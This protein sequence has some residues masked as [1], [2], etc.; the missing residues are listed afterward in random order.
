MVMRLKH[1]SHHLINSAAAFCAYVKPVRNVLKI[2]FY[3]R[4]VDTFLKT[5]AKLGSSL[6][7]LLAKPKNNWQNI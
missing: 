6:A 4:G 2:S 1:P 7:F 5:L 3:Y